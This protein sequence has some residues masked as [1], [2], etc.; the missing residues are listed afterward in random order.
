MFVSLQNSFWNLIPNVMVFGSGI[1]GK[2]LDYDDEALVNGVSA[3]RRDPKEF[4]CLS[5][6][7][8][9]NQKNLYLNQSLKQY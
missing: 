2:W 4:T 9:L 3:L 1:L 5:D 7:W 6:M 8:E